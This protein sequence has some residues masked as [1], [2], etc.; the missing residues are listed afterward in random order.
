MQAETVSQNTSVFG[1]VVNRSLGELINLYP[2]GW[3]WLVEMAGGQSWLLI[4]CLLL[5]ITFM[6]D[7]VFRSSIGLLNRILK[8][9]HYVF[10]KTIS[11][12]S[13]SPVSFYIWFSGG[14]I[15]L[16]AVL[17]HFAIFTD[18]IPHISALKAMIGIISM[19]WFAMRWVG[20]MEDYLFHLQEEDKKWDAITIEALGKVFRLTVFIITGLVILSAMGVNLTGLIAFGGMGGIAVGFA[21]KDILGNVLGGLMLYW[22]KPF[23][24]G[25]WIRSAD[26][27]IEGTVESIG[28]RMTVVRTFDKRPLYIPNGT[29]SQIAIENPSRMT[30]RRIRET[31]GVRYGDVDKVAGITDAI[32]K[33]MQDHPEIASDQTLIVNF[34][35]YN[36]S[37][38]D[39]L[40]YGFTHTT[41]W[42]TFHKV[43][44]DV[45][46]KIAQI[47]AD[48]GAEMAFPTRTLYVEDSVQISQTEQR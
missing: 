10:F 5:M 34:N 18:L 40:I 29:F 28:W 39:I 12:S 36:Q 7:F 31:I 19:A 33:M 32:R 9:K 16:V 21:A 11:V 27:E 37:T 6:I 24:V 42:V 14:I 25:D 48:K 41:D 23:A 26:K 45:L 2:D 8:K 47:V 46:L 43:K 38:L 30:H 20:Q 35:V 1:E 17:S 44:E 22:D 13:V 4:I 3:R 15:A